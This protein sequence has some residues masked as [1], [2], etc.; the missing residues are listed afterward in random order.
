[1]LIAFLALALSRQKEK[2]GA[3]FGMHPGCKNIFFWEASHACW[4]VDVGSNGFISDSIKPIIRDE[5]LPGFGFRECHL[6]LL[7]I[8]FAHMQIHGELDPKIV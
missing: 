1:M 5:P 8:S 7:E 6:I 2:A 3:F 4:K